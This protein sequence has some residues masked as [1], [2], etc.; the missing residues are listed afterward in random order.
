M[1]NT[2]ALIYQTNVRQKTVRTT[3]STQAS[4]SINLDVSRSYDQISRQVWARVRKSESVDL[5][6]SSHVFRTDQ[7]GFLKRIKFF[8]Y[9]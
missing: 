7:N 8:F 2:M 9:Q 1:L 3:I 6:C 4:E 5:R